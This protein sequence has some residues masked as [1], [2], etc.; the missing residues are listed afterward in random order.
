MSFCV[1]FLAVSHTYTCRSTVPHFS[2]L[3][4]GERTELRVDPAASFI[5]RGVQVPAAY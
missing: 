1:A 2:S 4:G 3:P 5:I